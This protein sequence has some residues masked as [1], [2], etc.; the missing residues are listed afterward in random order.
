MAG[1]G[2]EEVSLLS[3]STGDYS[4]L[5]PLLKA[6][7][8]RHA[9]EKVAV[10]LPSLR[11]GSLTPELMEE[12]KKVRKTGFTLAPEAG[13]ERLRQVINKGITEDDLLDA[14]SAAFG[15]GW[16]LIKLYFMTGLP[17]ETDADLDAIIDLAARVKRSGR[18]TQGGADVNVSV[19]TFVPKAH[20]PFPWE[21][22]IGIAETKR[23]QDGLRD[24]LRQ[25]K[26]R[27]KWHD[28][29]LSFLEGVFARGDRRLGQVLEAAVD[30][31]CRFDGWSE[32]F[33]FASWQE[34]FAAVGIEPAFY[35]RE[36]DEDEILPWDHLDCGVPKDF[37]L[38]ERQQ[39]AG[40]RRHRRL[41]RRLHRLRR[42]RFRSGKD[43][44]GRACR[45]PLPA[46]APPSDTG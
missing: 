2:Y 15:L 23:R 4:C 8:A 40:R 35:L 38:A 42:L 36:R 32:H 7:M 10:S 17:T 30:A 46:S 9:E 37:F 27:F 19:S 16:R 33:D 13:S 26:L 45:D 31:G 18:G 14:T 43:A 41:P 1:S 44:P 34:A 12:I 39:V 3:L 20:T 11:V 21:A 24:G 25:K 6:L 29:E 22:Q 5:E 28:A